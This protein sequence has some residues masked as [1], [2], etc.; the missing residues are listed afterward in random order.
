[1]TIPRHSPTMTSRSDDAA[2][3]IHPGCPQIVADPDRDVYCVRCQERMAQEE[4]AVVEA[5]RREDAVMGYPVQKFGMPH[6]RR[7]A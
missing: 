4:A 5:I 6:R 3:C 2:R 1:M 7:R